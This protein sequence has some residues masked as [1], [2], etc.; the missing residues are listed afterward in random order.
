MKKRRPIAPRFL[1]RVFVVALAACLPVWAGLAED[2][3]R[4]W[5]SGDHA[6]ALR[7][8]DRVLDEQPEDFQALL[9][10]AKL[11]SWSNRFDEAIERYDRAIAVD[12]NDRD[13]VL[14]RAQTLSWDRRFEESRADFETLIENDPSDVDALLGLA[15]TYAWSS[16]SPEAGNAFRR[17]LDV[18]PDN[19]DA[20]I[21]LA[22][23][24]LWAG[25]IGG[26]TEQAVA[27]KQ[28]HP[29]HVEVVKLHDQVSRSAGASWSVDVSQ[30]DDTDD[31]LLRS[32]LIRGG[33]GLG[34]QIRLD[35]GLGRYDMSGPSGDA[36]IDN[37]NATIGFH[38]TRGQRLSA[39]IGFDALTRVDNTDEE[40]V[41][42]GL[43]YSWGLDR[44]WQVHGSAM[45]NSIRYS[46]EITNNNITFDQLQLRTSGAAGKSFR[47][48]ADAGVAD[49]SDG[50]E[51]M[52]ASAGFMYRLP[53][54]KV[55]MDVGY[56]AR[57][58]DYDQDLANGYFDPQ[59]FLAHLAQFQ[60]NDEFGKRGNYYRLR[61]GTGVQ[62]F[63]VGGVDVNNDT[64]LVIGGTLGFRVTK[65]MILEAYAEYGDYAAATA[66]GFAST[67]VGVRLLWRAGL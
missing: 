50:N 9:R 16:R 49:F 52:T 57:A 44:R 2:A 20:R 56:T 21:A 7:F 66:S 30:I 48:N 55:T 46:P 65:R 58:M 37:F 34:H 53:V 39:T 59:D 11:L 24:D 41:L 28:E 33:F 32:Y 40:E 12:P 3:D 5:N 67:M 13:A 64:V 31:N 15:R 6:K 61:L 60:L 10:S 29:E 8:Y 22:Y 54:R 14:G 19:V 17:V 43:S 62:S 38:P 45:R 27:L 4:A 35:L 1:D 18:D 23:L 25:E 42:G 26:A 47:I 51:R 63:T 36:S